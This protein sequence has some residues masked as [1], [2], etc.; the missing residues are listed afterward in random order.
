MPATNASALRPDANTF[1]KTGHPEFAFE[2]ECE[3][4]SWSCQAARNKSLSEVSARVH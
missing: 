1:V 2:D 4:G 3:R